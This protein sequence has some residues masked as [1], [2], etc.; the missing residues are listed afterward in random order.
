MGIRLIVGRRSRKK[1]KN[2][3]NNIKDGNKSQNKK[4]AAIG[5]KYQDWKSV[6][7]EKSNMGN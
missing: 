4:Y 2:T 3:S 7:I 5:E 6:N 1:S